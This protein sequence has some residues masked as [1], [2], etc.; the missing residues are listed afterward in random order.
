MKRICKTDQIYMTIAFQFNLVNCKDTIIG[1]QRLPGISGGEMKRLAF[2]SEVRKIYF[3]R[4][5]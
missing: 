3:S 4:I 1:N 5:L 2:A